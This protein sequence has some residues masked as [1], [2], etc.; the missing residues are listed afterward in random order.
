MA[1]PCVRVRVSAA[2]RA[3][4]WAAGAALP[5]YRAR[6]RGVPTGEGPL[7][8]APL[9]PR[10]RRRPRPAGMNRKK[11]QKLTDTLTKNCKN[12]K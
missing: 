10:R 2:S 4:Q 5:W 9:G 3:S 7:G 11:L 1:T 6:V 8:R 12:C